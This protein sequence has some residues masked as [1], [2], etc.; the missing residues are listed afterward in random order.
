MLLNGVLFNN[1]MHV[2]NIPG[3]HN[4][5]GY[6][7]AVSNYLKGGHRPLSSAVPTIIAKNGKIV[8]IIGA[9]GSKRIVTSI[10][11][12]YMNEKLNA[13]LLLVSIS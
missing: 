6:P 11:Q 10:A 13:S 4:S 3:R 5:Y 2:F 7:S 1:Q 9:T 12:V 8:M